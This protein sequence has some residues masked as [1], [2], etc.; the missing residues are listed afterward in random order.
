MI[1]TQAMLKTIYEILILPVTIWFV[2]FVKRFEGVDEY[3]T[4]L[5]YN[6]FRL[7]EI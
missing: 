1:F 4:N 6:L 7:K 5:S 2:G 3:D